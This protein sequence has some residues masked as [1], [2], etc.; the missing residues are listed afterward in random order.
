MTQYKKIH[1]SW[2]MDYCE[3]HETICA[4]VSDELKNQIEVARNLLKSNDFMHCIEILPPIDFIRDADAEKLNEHC[5]YE[6]AN[7]SVFKHALYLT[8]QSKWDASYRA[9]YDATHLL[10]NTT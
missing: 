9:E 10:V 7:L 8:I 6:I 4:Y 3:W 5:R 2:A 1:R